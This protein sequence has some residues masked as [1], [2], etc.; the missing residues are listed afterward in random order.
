MDTGITGLLSTPAKIIPIEAGAVLHG[1]KASDVGFA[2]FGE[3]YFSKIRKGSVKGWKKHTRMTL[4]LIVPVGS[5]RFI[6]YDSRAESPTQGA[7]YD[8]I[9]GQENYARLTVPPGLW[10]AFQG[11]GDSINLL[12]N[13]ASIHHDPNESMA[14]PLSSPEMPHVTW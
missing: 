9:I 7:I 5:I 12:L 6:V 1:V 4:N 13:I 10:M 14:L 3:A 8:D 2:G 11:V